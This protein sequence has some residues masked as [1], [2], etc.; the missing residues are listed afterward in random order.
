[1]WTLLLAGFLF[2]L[3]INPAQD[4]VPVLNQSF[5]NQAL[6]GALKDQSRAARLPAPWIHTASK[7]SNPV[8]IEVVPP[9]SK[10]RSASVL[11]TPEASR[12]DGGCPDRPGPAAAHEL[13]LSLALSRWP[14]APSHF[15]F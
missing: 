10:I 4:L 14:I 11:I 13:G 9:L 15:L 3:G 8:P 12:P 6:R 1:M 5:L 2:K 7:Y